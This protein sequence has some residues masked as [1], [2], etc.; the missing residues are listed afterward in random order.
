LEQT[1]AA[2]VATTT[3]TTTTF[4]NVILPPDLDTNDNLENGSP[5]TESGNGDLYTGPPC[6]P[7]S[8]AAT[9][10]TH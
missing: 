5:V 8:P 10:P 1:D 3:T 6:P 2:L 9:C 7:G 4:V